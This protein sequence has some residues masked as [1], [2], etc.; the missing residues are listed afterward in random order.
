MR[1]CIKADLAKK[2]EG[3]CE[4]IYNIPCIEGGSIYIIDGIAFL[5]SQNEAMFQ[6]SDDLGKIVLDQLLS[7][8]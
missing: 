3:K 1:K 6:S 8:L 2:I 5:Q 7:I 4:E